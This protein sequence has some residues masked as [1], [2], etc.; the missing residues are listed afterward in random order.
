M[1]LN[2][3]NCLC[4]AFNRLPRS[5]DWGSR[6]VAKLASTVGIHNIMSGSKYEKDISSNAFKSYGKFNF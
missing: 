1:G 3:A 5:Q 6:H 4:I 2:W